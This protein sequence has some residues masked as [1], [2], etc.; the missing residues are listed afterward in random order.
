MQYLKHVVEDDVLFTKVILKFKP[1][2][3]SI[4]IFVRVIYFESSGLFWGLGFLVP[5]AVFLHFCF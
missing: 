4:E 5:R 3:A 1:V 2:T